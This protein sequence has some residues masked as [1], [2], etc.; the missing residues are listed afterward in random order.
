MAKRLR[1]PTSLSSVGGFLRI[2]WP[3]LRTS[4]TS[5]AVSAATVSP[6]A[7]DS[8]VSA[9]RVASQLRALGAIA[10]VSCQLVLV[11]L[12]I[13]QFQL[14]NRTFF[15]VMLLGTVGFVVH[16]LLPMQYR[17]P[18]FTLLSLASIM[19]ALGP[20][21]GTALVV[22]GLVLIGICHLPVRLAVRVGLLLGVG[23]LFAVWRMELL[24][25]PWSV[26]IWPLLASM[27]MFRLA[28]YLYTLQHDKNR[29][30]PA[31]TLGYFF[32][33]PNVCFPLY[34]VIDYSTFIRTYHD[35]DVDKIY[36]TGMRWI[37]RGLLHLILY[38][39]VYLY[40]AGDPAEL[41]TLGDLVRFL[42][43]TFLLYL[44][45]S[46]QFH[47]CVG[48][49]YLFGF[50]LPETHHLYYLA[51]S[52]TDF[53]RRI[54]IYW[55]D[56]M[57]KLVYYPSYFQLRRW[58]DNM[59]LVVATIVVFLGTW[60]L[61]SYQWFWLRGGFPLAPQDALFWG[62]LGAL[63]VF[64][65]L[66]EMK[67]PRKRRLGR[68]PAWSASLALRRLGTF[69]AI[70]VLWSLW[71]ADSIAAW[72]TMWRVAGN[73][74][75]NDLWLLAGLVL[76]GL[77]VAG[78][79]WSA[80]ETDDNVTGV[81]YR[82]P[83]LHSTALL[84]GMVVAGNT[85]LYERHSPQLADTV[86]SLQRSTLNTRDAALQHRG[87]YEKLDNESRMSAEL[88]NTQAR[89]PANW[90]NNEAY[91]A[92]DDFMLGD[93]RPDAHVVFKGQPLTTNRWGMRDRDR[94]LAKPEG[95]YRIALVGPSHAM[96]AGVADGETFA[97]FLEERLNRS[98]TPETHIRYEVLNFA[99][100]DYSLL[101]QL[102]ILEERVVMF[103]PDAVF[104]TNHR[105]IN[106]SAIEHLTQVIVSGVT[107]PYPDLDARIR[108]LGVNTP[109]NGGF[110][111]PFENV[112]A[113]LGAV[114]IKTRMLESEAASRLRPAVDS[115]VRWTLERMAT[116]TRQHGA[117]PVFVALDN[118]VEP[119]ASEV[120]ALRD[121][122]AA[123]FLVFNLF[124]LW[125]NREKSALRVAEWD[126]HPNAAGHQLIADR[127][128]ELMRQ[129]R[130]E[131]RL[132][133]TVPQ[134]ASEQ[135]VSSK[136]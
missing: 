31:Q 46:G 117:V 41:V 128:F 53:W 130:S 101:Q 78:R 123:G 44:R 88:W 129:H 110:P 1:V 26:A 105:G 17:L 113:L 16:A 121:A 119:S 133:T 55:K 94:L 21:D 32:M 48:I 65:S 82:Q 47:L 10:M 39:F 24:P 98:A 126:N 125:Q 49:L 87:Y 34:P 19:V 2:A 100:P 15:N 118:V 109:A 73:V 5:N 69:T 51:E 57:M 63:V 50:R 89:Q 14:E 99:V 85:P 58:G 64:G 102:A 27:F 80:R 56:F 91:R 116:V 71:S 7:S 84:L 132:G 37:V 74:T 97:R 108:R 124:D 75:L 13:N 134:L 61:H 35:R 43:G 136:Q 30:T 93:L 135:A 22:L 11:L 68:G 33:L 103:R 38:R 70:C 127:L 28:L 92:R 111:V 42:L 54:N 45:V 72:L 76:G 36:Q 23:T 86:A 59:A 90:A 114:G 107:I 6:T 112:R 115:L 77:L 52:F 4:G 9:P 66:R 8:V 96:G 25:A 122:D 67:R 12:V 18:F 62:M 104:T 81:F 60:L 29:P 20:V 3:W 83:A 79:A 95:T 120:R 106:R 131:L 40:L